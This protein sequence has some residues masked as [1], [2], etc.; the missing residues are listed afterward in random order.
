MT[1]GTWTA[2]VRHSLQSSTAVWLGMGELM[3]RF[4]VSLAALA[5]VSLLA[6]A[7]RAD[8]RAQDGTGKLTTV[9]ADLARASGALRPFSAQTSAGFDAMPKSTQD[10]IRGRGLRLSAGNEVQV[11]VLLDE[12]SEDTVNRMAAAGATVEIR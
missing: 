12:V 6:I 1:S 5:A 8:V 2:G 11:Y 10:A 3:G 9:L 7:Q 4:R